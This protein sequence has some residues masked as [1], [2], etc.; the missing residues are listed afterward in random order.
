M[1]LAEPLELE[2]PLE[3]VLD[4]P[5]PLTELLDRLRGEDLPAVRERR[6]AGGHDYGGAEEV[7][8]LLNSL[9][10]V[11]AHSD[12]ELAGRLLVVVLGDSPLDGDRAGEGGCG[13]PKRDHK[14]VAH[15]LDLGA[16][17]TAYLCPHHG[18]VN[19]QDLLRP[20][21]AQGIGELGRSYEVREQECDN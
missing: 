18:V 3:L 1:G 14:A 15:G 10:G 2:L 4:A 7:G 5:R 17:V 13:T 16:G 6:Y 11:Q 19:A 20:L 8:L 9:A 21:I 12:H